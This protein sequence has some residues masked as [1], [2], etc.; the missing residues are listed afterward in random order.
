MIKRI[1]YYIRYILAWPIFI[2]FRLSSSRAK[3]NINKDIRHYMESHHYQRLYNQLGNVG[4]LMFLFQ[5]SPSFRTI[6]YSRIG[7]K[8]RFIS[9]LYKGE[10]SFLLNAENIEG[11]IYAA[12]AFST[13][14]NAKHIGEN[15]SCRNCITIGNKSDAN[16]DLRPILGDNVTIGANAVIIGGVKVGDNVIIGAGA[17]VVNDVPNNCVVAG[18]PA[19]IIKRNN[20][21]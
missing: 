5:K 20:Y 1:I 18:N 10:Q 6:F 17:V 8:A 14:L 16:D 3:Q 9:W 7:I 13:I 11:G 19:K 2:L 12:H 4:E 15:F 21:D